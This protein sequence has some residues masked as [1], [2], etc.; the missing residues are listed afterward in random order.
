MS[1]KLEFNE[2]LRLK[3]EIECETIVII[4]LVHII[5]DYYRLVSLCN[6]LMAL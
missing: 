6:R 5:T 1:T 4:R 3:C 2:D